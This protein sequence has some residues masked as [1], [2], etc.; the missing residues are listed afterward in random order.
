M[1]TIEY[2]K[3]INRLFSLSTICCSISYI[4]IGKLQTLFFILDNS[5]PKILKCALLLGTTLNQDNKYREKETIISQKTFD[6]IIDDLSQYNILYERV[7]EKQTH[8]CSRMT[9]D[10]ELLE[11][12]F[13]SQLFNFN[14][15]I[16]EDLARNNKEIGIVWKRLKKLINVPLIKYKL[17]K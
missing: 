5:Q 1:N 10:G 11:L 7:M 9:L 16:S 14:L 12:N 13:K 3:K 15:E 2:Q 4:Q 6:R 17:F 8:D